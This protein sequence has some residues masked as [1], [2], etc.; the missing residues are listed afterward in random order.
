MSK[1]FELAV[2]WCGNEETTDEVLTNIA[3]LKLHDFVEG[4]G[5]GGNNVAVFRGTLQALSELAVEYTLDFDE[6]QL[7][8]WQELVGNI[9]EV[10]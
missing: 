6:P 3:G 2:D 5:A 7:E 8:Y 9:T 10:G 1:Q 4:C